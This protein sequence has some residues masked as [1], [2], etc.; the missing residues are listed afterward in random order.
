[1][2]ED[3]S[4]ELELDLELARLVNAFFA[5]GSAV[6]HISLPSALQQSVAF[7]R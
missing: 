3:P 5:V 7:A 6:V 1:M 2:V 4:Y